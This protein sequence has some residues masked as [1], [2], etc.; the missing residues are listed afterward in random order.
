M[1]KG[2][3]AISMPNVPK[4][5]ELLD[6]GAALPTAEK[7]IRNESFALIFNLFDFQSAYGA[8]IQPLAQQR[9][10]RI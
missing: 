4:H 7:L 3:R 2:Q 8:A 6:I 9:V 5:S 1:P 10:L